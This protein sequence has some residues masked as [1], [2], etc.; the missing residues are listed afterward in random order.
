MNRR[1]ARIIV[2]G[3][4][5]LVLAAGFAPSQ[6]TP[7]LSA[8]DRLKTQIERVLR[9]QDGVVGV[10]VRH[11]ESGRGTSVNG[12]VPFP[13]A[14][15]FKV[16]ILVELLAQSLE[17]KLSLEDEI[18]VQKED[19]HAGS[20]MISSL[21]TPGIKLSVLN[22]AHF[23]MMISDN[24]ATDMLLAKVGPAAVTA[25]MRTLGIEGITVG[26]S[27]QEMIRD[28]RTATAGVSGRE[29]LKQAI[30]KYGENPDDAATPL[31]M[32][33]LL[34]KIVRREILDPERCDVVLSIMR[35]CE[36]GEK[37]IKG[38]LP[39]GTQVA[40]KTGTIAGTV[41]DCGLIMLPDGQGRVVLTVMS[42]DFTGPTEDVEELIA[43]IA[44]FVYDCFYFTD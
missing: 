7:K 21:M 34:E 10:A 4:V 1:S 36:T 41:N 28:Y 24:S 22:M 27:C 5:L 12:D 26:R 14:S 25:R 16:P 20:G 33:A 2:A 9:R 30:V 3:S 15:A 29:A 31:A 18:A 32:N 44:R 35:K 38:Q 42:K 17:G 8:L 6:E 19:Q 11:I 13:M 43:R 40:H 37:R 39:P 23:M